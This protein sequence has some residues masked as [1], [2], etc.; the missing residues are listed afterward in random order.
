VLIG[1]CLK[2]FNNI[3]D[4]GSDIVCTVC[5]IRNTYRV[6]T[7]LQY[8]QFTTNSGQPI[9]V[10]EPQFTLGVEMDENGPIETNHVAQQTFDSLA[11]H[12]VLASSPFVVFTTPYLERAKSKIQCTLL[13]YFKQP[14]YRYGK[15][16]TGSRMQSRTQSTDIL[17]RKN[18]NVI[19]KQ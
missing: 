13:P 14:L 19:T 1:T 2:H 16:D 15:S 4:T 10:T 5:A 8:R 18:G 17:D 12:S 6:N 11:Q 9:S 7:M 3:V